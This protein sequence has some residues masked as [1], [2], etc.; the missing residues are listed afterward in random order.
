MKTIA[1]A[2]V[3]DNGRYLICKRPIKIHRQARGDFRAT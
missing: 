2:L 1:T 3:C